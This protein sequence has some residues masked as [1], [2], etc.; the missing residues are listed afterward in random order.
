[1]TGATGLD[2]FLALLLRQHEESLDTGAA[3]IRRGLRHREGDWRVIRAYARMAETDRAPA[4]HV[5]GRLGRQLRRI[6]ERTGGELDPEQVARAARALVVQSLG[7]RDPLV[8]EAD[9]AFEEMESV[10]GGIPLRWWWRRARGK[11]DADDPLLA[12]EH[13]LE[14]LEEQHAAVWRRWVA[15]EDYS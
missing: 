12:A 14:R 6:D 13:D 8:Q 4:R 10:R 7:V 15:R 5:V 9:A 3:A 11:V 1:M 2:E